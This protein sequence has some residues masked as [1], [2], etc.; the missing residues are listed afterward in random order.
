MENS[1]ISNLDL[2]QIHNCYQNGLKMEIWEWPPQPCHSK[3]YIH[4]FIIEI[5]KLKWNAS[6]QTQPKVIWTCEKRYEQISQEPDNK[7]QYKIIICIDFIPIRK[8]T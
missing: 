3:F 5:I 8:T 2:S 7:T 1:R 4:D 6:S